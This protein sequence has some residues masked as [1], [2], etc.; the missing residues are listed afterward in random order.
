MSK[1]MPIKQAQAPVR[2]IT[3]GPQQHYFGYYD[4][5]QFDSSGRFALG[6][7]CNII[8]RQQ[9]IDDVAEVGLID[10][11]NDEVWIPLGQ[12]HAWNWQCGCLAQWLHRKSGNIIYNDGARQM[13][14]LDVGE[15]TK[16]RT[17]F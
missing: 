9:E 15:I 2:A 7:A 10:L 4:K 14:L 17:I 5:R 12:T 11:E 3:R 6:L 8:G 13:Y 1:N 16:P